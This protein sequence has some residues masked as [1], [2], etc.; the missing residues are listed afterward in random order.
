MTRPSTVAGTLP[1]ERKFLGD[2]L[3]LRRA[4]IGESAA[5]KLVQRR[6]CAANVGKIAAEAGQNVGKDHVVI[7]GGHVVFGAGRDHHAGD[8]A[9][10]ADFRRRQVRLILC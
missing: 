1:A 6:Q 4:E 7:G 8:A 3:A 9:E 5:G 10:V 2:R